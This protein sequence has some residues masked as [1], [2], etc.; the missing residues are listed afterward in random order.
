MGSSGRLSVRYFIEI[1]YL[2]THFHG[3][4]LQDGVPTIQGE[5]EKALSTVLNTP[6]FIQGSSRTDTGVHARQ[7]FAHFDVAVELTA[8]VI[9]RLNRFLPRD[10]SVRNLYPV[11]E[12]T[13]ARFDAIGRKYIYRILHRKDPFKKEFSA[14]YT[15]QP[16]VALMNRAAEILFNYTDFQC[17]SKVKTNVL[18]FNCTLEEAVWREADGT[19]E[20]H[21]TANRFL[22]GMVRA[23]V[24]TLLDVGYGKTSLEAFEK[25]ILSKDRT[26]AGSASKAEGLTLERVYYP[27]RYFKEKL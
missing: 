15:R 19:L 8:P 27:E 2:G 20:F 11:K 13:H 12:D 5:V 7:Q 6:V 17:F 3:W 10:I 21:I 22:R 23:V 1:S 25:I 24:G 16:D 18:T 4:Q 9:D 14:L 26:K